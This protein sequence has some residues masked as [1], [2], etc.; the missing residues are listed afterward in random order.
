MRASLRILITLKPIGTVN[1]VR[2]M[3]TPEHDTVNVTDDTTGMIP[4]A[5]TREG[6]APSTA[7][8]ERCGHD[9]DR[10][11]FKLTARLLKAAEHST[12][13][14]RAMIWLHHNGCYVVLD[15]EGVPSQGTASAWLKDA[16]LVPY[17]IVPV[18][19]RRTDEL[20]TYMSLRLLPGAK[21]DMTAIGLMTSMPNPLSWVRFQRRLDVNYWRSLD[22]V[23]AEAPEWAKPC[24]N[25]DVM[26]GRLKASVS[27]QVRWSGT[28]PSNDPSLFF[29]N[30]V[31]R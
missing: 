4:L 26:L 23:R 18:Y 30:L 8:T 10:A 31:E 5:Y 28:V 20:V 27:T 19:R 6:L 16:T 3:T 15:E 25:G 17:L 9:V 14:L 13:F 24:D 29:G 22:E 11:Y 12:S 2:N 1:Q 21:D 7:T